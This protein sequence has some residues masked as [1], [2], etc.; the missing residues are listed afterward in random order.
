M[1]TP[2]WPRGLR[3]FA[4][5]DQAGPERPMPPAL[6]LLYLGFL[7]MP[8]TFGERG[9]GWLW[10]TLLSLPVFLTLYLGWLRTR[11]SASLP[12]VLGMALLCYALQPFNPFANTYLAYAAAFAPLALPGLL[13]P[14]LLTAALL[15]LLAIEVMLLGQPLLIIAISVLICTVCGR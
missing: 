7:F 2:D 12:L 14:L 10:A 13:R 1:K 6:W 4:A 9:W 5:A 11:W 15:A 3:R 8:F